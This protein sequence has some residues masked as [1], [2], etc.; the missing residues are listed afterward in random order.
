MAALLSAS[1]VACG[2]RSDT[3]TSF[4]QPVSFKVRSLRLDQRLKV[5]THG[6]GDASLAYDCATIPWRVT[7]A[8]L[9]AATLRRHGCLPTRRR[10]LACQSSRSQQSGAAQPH[11]PQVAFVVG[12]PGSGKGTQCTQISKA[13]GYKFLSAGELLRAERQRDGSPLKEEIDAAIDSGRTVPSTIIAALLEQAMRAEG[14]ADSRFVID[15][16]PRSR[17]QL[18]GWETTLSTRVKLLFCL[19]IDVGCEEMKKRLLGR[20]ESSGR[21]DDNED[22][23]EKRFTTYEEETGPLLA[24]FDSLGL[25][26]RVDGERAVE[27]VWLDVQKLFQEVHDQE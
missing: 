26:Q 25:L 23:I 20:A 12:G 21:S 11:G 1:V 27:E 2:A 22:V 15:G 4:S 6:Q 19:S 18:A 8:T 10:I 13:F 9:C 16:Y 24:H 17:E 3:I 5:A 14:W 7:A